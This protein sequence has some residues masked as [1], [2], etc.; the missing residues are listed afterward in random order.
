MIFVLQ[1]RWEIISTVL[2]V[3]LSILNPQDA[4]RKELRGDVEKMRYLGHT[5]QSH[6]KPCLQYFKS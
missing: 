5:A 6:Q 1:L 4:M 2:I 3:A